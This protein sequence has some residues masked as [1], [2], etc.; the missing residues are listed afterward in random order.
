M[1]LTNLM[2]EKQ[3]MINNFYKNGASLDLICNSSG[4]PLEKVKK[5][6]KIK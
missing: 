1:I 4:L 3:K 2:E 5:I 6:L